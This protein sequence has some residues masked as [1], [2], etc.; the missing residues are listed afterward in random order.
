LKYNTGLAGDTTGCGDNFAGGIIASA[1]WQLR[2]KKPGELDIIDACA[3]GIAS[4]GFTC[5]YIGGT[6]LEWSKGEKFNLVNPY[7]E[8]YRKQIADLI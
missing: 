7:Y 2:Y 4:G 6:Y 3:W 8:L 1:A 5:F